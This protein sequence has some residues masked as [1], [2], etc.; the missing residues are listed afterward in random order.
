M[1]AYSPAG[2]TIESL[3][4]WS[5]TPYALA[6]S[7]DG[8]A[9]WVAG[10]R[11]IDRLVPAT[12]AI[13]KAVDDARG[14]RAGG[15]ADVRCRT[16]LLRAEKRDRVIAAQMDMAVGYR[17]GKLERAHARIVPTAAHRIKRLAA[18]PIHPDQ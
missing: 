2:G 10:D 8:S 12:G 16:R 9:L 11:R 5:G 1:T 3:S 6:A 17:H 13:E 4:G 7:P 15:V 14:L 18:P